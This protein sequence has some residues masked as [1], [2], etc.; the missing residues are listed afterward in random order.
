MADCFD[1]LCDELNVKI[2]INENV[3]VA[4][5]FEL[6]G[7]HFDLELKTVSIPD[8][9]HKKLVKFTEESIK[10]RW[11]TGR[12]TESFSGQIMH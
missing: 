5:R 12:A 6:Y 7:F 8:A 4:Q 3:D 2:S 11:L 10:F 9:K 1:N